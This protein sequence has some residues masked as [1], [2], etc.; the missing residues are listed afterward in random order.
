[1]LSSAFSFG[2]QEEPHKPSILSK[3]NR[4]NRGKM[5]GTPEK[6]SRYQIIS[7]FKSLE[8]DNQL[9]RTIMQELKLNY[10]YFEAQDISDISADVS[11]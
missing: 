10:D 3:G 1:M 8:E 4:K 11:L 7:Q 5:E 6:G 2:R 9:A